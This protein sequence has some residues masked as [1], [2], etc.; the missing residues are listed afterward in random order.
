VWIGGIQGTALADAGYGIE[1]DWL[2]VIVPGIEGKPYID[3][4]AIGE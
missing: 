2:S 3:G 1:T 4:R